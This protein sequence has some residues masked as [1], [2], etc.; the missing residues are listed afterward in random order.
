MRQNVLAII[1]NPDWKVLIWKYTVHGKSWTF[2]KW[3]KEKWESDHE[4]LFREIYEET[5][6]SLENL[7]IILE[8]PEVYEK[9]F[10]PEE[11]KWKIANKGEH[12]IWKQEKI[13]ILAF[14]GKWDIN[15]SITNELSEYKWIK[16]SEIKKYISNQD[17]LRQISNYI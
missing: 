1:Q 16:K 10:S 13:F 7:Q 5:W 15:L 9:L 8:V 11:I 3:W 12:H 2:P 4:A 6:I 14:D 17:F